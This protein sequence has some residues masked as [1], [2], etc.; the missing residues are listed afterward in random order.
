MKKLYLMR[1]G[2]TLFN[3]Q[4]RI[5]GWCDSPLTQLGQEQARQMGARIGAEGVRFDHAFSSTAERCS[6]TLELAMEAMGQ[7]LPYERLKGIREMNFGSLEAMPC[8]LEELDPEKCRTYYL[9]FGGES[10]DTVLQRMIDTLAQVMS[11]DDVQNAF[12][13]SH[14]GA[15]FNFLRGIQDPTE[16]L[17]KGWGNCLCCVYSFDEEKAAEAPDGQGA[18]PFKLE[19]ILRLTG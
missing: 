12:A 1:H 8:F 2:E 6:D 5:Q 18:G 14:G 17:A 16:E 19:K 15:I 9:Q 3:Q 13:V 7:V 10:S 4:K 11:R